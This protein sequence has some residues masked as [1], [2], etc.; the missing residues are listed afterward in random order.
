MNEIYWI[1]RLDGIQAFFAICTILAA[2][3]IV[4]LFINILASD[5]EDE[6][7]KSQ[8]WL[9]VL[10]CSLPFFVLTLIFIPSTKDALL[11]YGLGGSLDYV[12]GND[13]AKKLPEKAVMALDRYL[14]E[15]NKDEKEK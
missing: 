7:T 5:E 14:E 12:K 10:L 2:L 8:K 11:I 1:T 15:L 4:I 6:K 13:T 9:K 3:A